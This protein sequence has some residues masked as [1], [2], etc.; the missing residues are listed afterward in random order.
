MHHIQLQVN[1]GCYPQITIAPMRPHRFSLEWKHWV[2][3]KGLCHLGL[4]CVNSYWVPRIQR[5]VVLWLLSSV[6]WSK[7]SSNKI[8][9][10]ILFYY[11]RIESGLMIDL[12]TINTDAHC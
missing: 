9:I 3:F 2:Y 11:F 6:K 5:K 7:I 1:I 12:L 10:V 8:C 4:Q